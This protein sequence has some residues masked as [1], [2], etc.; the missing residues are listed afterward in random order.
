MLV[1][2]KLTP[3]YCLLRARLTKRTVNYAVFR[4]GSAIANVQ[5]LTSSDQ[6]GK[7]TV[8]LAKNAPYDMNN[9]TRHWQKLAGMPDGARTLSI[10]NSPRMSEALHVELRAN[11]DEILAQA[12]QAFRSAFSGQ[13]VQRFQRNSDEIEVKA[14]YPEDDRQNPTDVMN[15]KVRTS[16]GQVVPLSSVATV[17]YCYTKDSITRINGQRAV[18]L[19]A[20]VNKDALSST[21]LVSLIQ[22]EVVPTIEQQFPTLGIH[23]A[24]KPNNK[25]KHKHR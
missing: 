8:E 22:R 7:V 24:G 6:A 25:Q 5:V 17:S 15:A 4:F 10:Q 19:S 2:D 12:G 16:N 18:Y 21:E 20:D 3:T 11:D 1:L 23:F 9:F 13:V 14:R